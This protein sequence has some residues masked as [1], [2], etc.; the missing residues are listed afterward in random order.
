MECVKVKEVGNFEYLRHEPVPEPGPGEVLVRVKVTGLCRTDLK[1]IR[2]GH[3]DLVLPRVPG[4]EVV[5][6]IEALGDGVRGFARD[7]RV[8][9]YPG[10][11]CGECPMCKIGAQNLCRH[12][13]IMG[14]HRD[15]GFAQY[16]KVPAQCLIPI[17][18]GL[19]FE[20]AVFAEP[21]SCCLNALELAG[22]KEG[23]LVGIWG[24]GPAGTLCFR[25]SR[26]L[27]A[28]VIAI[29][30]DGQRRSLIGGISSPKGIYFD[31]ALVAVGDPKAYEEA[32]SCLN[33]RGV[34]VAFSGL[35]PE[36]DTIPVSLNQLHYFEQ[37]I[38]GAYGCS[39]HHGAKALEFLAK[40][41]VNVRDL[42]SHRMP[43]RDLGLALSLVEE[44]RAM[45]I[46]LD[47][48]S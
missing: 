20:E 1:L 45:K 37:S 13:E 12:M 11:W 18:E 35:L 21:L 19:S 31:I 40:G 42:I 46:L 41:K 48:F 4:E 29:E 14:F 27:G 25:L 30:P 5:G 47:P 43:L 33:P 36:Q 8:Y 7:E 38:V 2:H 34:L 22:V 32:L 39:F 16:V 28:E 44:R 9:V 15:G 17:P 23:K 26:A 24:A 3:R 6:T 10:L